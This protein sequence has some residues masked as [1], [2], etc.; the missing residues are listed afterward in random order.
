MY[1]PSVDRLRGSDD[2]PVTCWHCRSG[3]FASPK[4]SLNCIVAWVRADISALLCI[5]STA[6]IALRSVDRELAVHK[7]LSV[8]LSWAPHALTAASAASQSSSSNPAAKPRR[9]ARKYAS[10]AIHSCQFVL[11][12]LATA[13]TAGGSSVGVGVNKTSTASLCL[14]FA[15]VT[16][17][18]CFMRWFCC[19]SL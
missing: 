18:C 4:W 7:A 16:L 12:R 2:G 3:H 5:S 14:G 11:S 15:A 13:D 9:S 10:V 8:Y 6:R 1:A 19:E 17:S